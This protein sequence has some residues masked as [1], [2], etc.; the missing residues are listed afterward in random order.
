MHKFNKNL[1]IQIKYIVT[2]HFRAF[3]FVN[4]FVN[5][6]VV[7]ICT[8]HQWIIM[9]IYLLL[10]FIYT[11]L[12]PDDFSRLSLSRS[13]VFSSLEME[14]YKTVIMVFRVPMLHVFLPWPKTWQR[15]AE[16][17]ETREGIPQTRGLTRPFSISTLSWIG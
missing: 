14:Q 6:E 16:E 3:S 7:Q 1:N 5:K 2:I 12:F 4:S 10:I 15:C 8:I 13:V 9:Q 17:S 11:L